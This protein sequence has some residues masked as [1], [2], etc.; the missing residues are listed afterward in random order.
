MTKSIHSIDLA[1]RDNWLDGPLPSSEPRPPSG[2]VGLERVLPELVRLFC[3][4]TDCA[5]ELGVEFG[6]ST[7]VLAQLFTHVVGVD[8]FVG[9]AHSGQKED[10]CELTTKN[11]AR[12]PNITLHQLDYREFIR[13]VDAGATEYPAQ[14]SIIH[15]DMLHDFETTYTAG[16]WAVDHAPVVIFH[17]TNAYWP[18]VPDAIL[19]I[20]EETGREFYDYKP[21][22]GLGILV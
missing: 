12:W 8:T 19:K 4:R 9:D 1:P 17:D 15:V 13:R 14:Y 22:N 11:L 20:A 2:W 21:C 16:R 10:H 5:L 7:A 18:A 3:R 6:Y